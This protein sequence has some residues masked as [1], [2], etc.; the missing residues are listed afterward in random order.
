[1]YFALLLR[2][3]K[4]VNTDSV[5]FSKMME[6]FVQDDN[7]A[8]EYIYLTC[9]AYCTNTLMAKRKCTLEDAEDLFID[10]VLI[11]RRKIISGEISYLTN[12]KTYLYKI[13]DNNFLANQKRKASQASKEDAIINALYDDATELPSY[14]L[15]SARHAWNLLSEKCKD[16]VYLFYVEAIKMEEIAK[17]LDLANADTAKSTKSRCYKKFV[18]LAKAYITKAEDEAK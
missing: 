4:K 15:E 10:A 6:S 12:L 2:K 1:M 3:A 18:S 5:K 13:C 7:K 14:L 17:L 11:F 8:F 16:I 9:G